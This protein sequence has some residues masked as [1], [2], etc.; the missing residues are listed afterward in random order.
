MATIREPTVKA[1]A[2]TLVD[3][4][5]ARKAPHV[6]TGMNGWPTL[7]GVSENCEYHSHSVRRALIILEDRDEI[8]VKPSRPSNGKS[9]EIMTYNPE[10][11]P[12]ADK[13]DWKEMSEQ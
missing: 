11:A 12:K 1:V 7:T 4:W 3:V 10:T 13:I 6:E 2:Q 8:Q 5:E 9:V